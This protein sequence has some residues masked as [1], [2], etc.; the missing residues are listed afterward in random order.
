MNELMLSAESKARAHEVA[1]A[2][3]RPENWYHLGDD[4]PIG[5]DERNLRRCAPAVPGD[6][7]PHVIQLDAFRVVFSYTLH[8]GVLYRHLSIS[9]R[10]A[11]EGAFPHPTA[12]Y[13]IASWFGFTG[14]IVGPHPDVI[15]GRGSDWQIDVREAPIAHIVLVQRIG[16]AAP[17]RNA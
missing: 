2:C 12:V 13:T 6:A 17:R 9:V 3:S 1:L 8:A 16:A 10:R 4:E 14:G 11:S 15:C 5:R 7:A